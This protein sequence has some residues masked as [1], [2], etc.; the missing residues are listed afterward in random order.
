MSV[1]TAECSEQ[2]AWKR[3]SN[4]RRRARPPWK[5]SGLGDIPPL[6]ASHP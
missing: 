2:V 4:R 5:L 1:G 6:E 3:E